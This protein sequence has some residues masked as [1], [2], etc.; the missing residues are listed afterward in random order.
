MRVSEACGGG[1]A[2]AVVA[3][4]QHGSDVDAAG[5]ANGPLKEIASVF[6]LDGGWEHCKEKKKRKDSF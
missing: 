1:V 6:D 2:A 5:A 3:G 4:F